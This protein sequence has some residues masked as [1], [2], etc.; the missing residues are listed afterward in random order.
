MLNENLKRYRQEKS[1]TQEAVAEKLH[2][3]RQ[4]VSRWEKGVSVPDA[5]TLARIAELYQ[6]D[7]S[8]LLETSA[9]NSN[10]KK[11]EI[12]RELEK[13]SQELEI[14]KRYTKILWRVVLVIGIIITIIG[15]V[16]VV[17]GI[18]MY[19]IEVGKEDYN[20]QVLEGGMELYTTGIQRIPIGAA[21]ICV[22]AIMNRKR[23]RRGESL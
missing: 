12:E 10:L 13:I 16:G 5:E 21:M 19:E 15:L 9:S 18:V 23:R 1:L 11:E 17:G 2:V 4:T 8:Q 22:S 14:Q 3:V 7:M 20:M 6:V